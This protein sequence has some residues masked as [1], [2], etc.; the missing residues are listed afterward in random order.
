MSKKILGPNAPIKPDKLR[1]DF[2]GMAFALAI[3]EIGLE[4]GKL[5]T[6]NVSI[7]SHLYLA[8]HILLAVYIIASSWIGWQLSESQGNKEELRDPFSLSFI[9][10]L[11]DLLLVI[12]YFIIVQC[13]GQ[14]PEKPSSENQIF[15]SLMIFAVYVVWDIFTKLIV[16]DPTTGAAKRTKDLKSYLNRAYQAPFCFFIILFLVWPLRISTSPGKV[17]CIDT[18]L[19]SIFVLFRGLKSFKN[20]WK[21]SGLY[22]FLPLAAF[23]G[24]FIMF[25]YFI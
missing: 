11:L 25:R 6:D 15:W 18:M 17:I 20:D 5:Y 7:R 13:I 4:I 1:T 10:L 3:G 14:H 19:I 22:I 12:C 2:I 16:E 8:T 21:K 23:V 24:V 9:I